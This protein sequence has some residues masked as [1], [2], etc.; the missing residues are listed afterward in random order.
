MSTNAF[1]YVQTQLDQYHSM[2]VTDKENIPYWSKRAHMALKAYQELLFTLLW[3]DKYGSEAVKE[4]SRVIKS[5]VFYMPEYRELCFS[6]LNS[7]D[8]VKLSKLYLKDLVETNHLFLKMLEEYATSSSRKILVKTKGQ[9]RKKM[10]RS[11]NKKGAKKSRKTIPKDDEEL[12]ELWSTVCH[13]IL[14]SVESSVGPS[15]EA[16]NVIPFDAASDTPI[17]EQKVTAVERISVFLHT[18]KYKEAFVLLK[19][20][21]EVWPDCREEFGEQGLDPVDETLVLKGIFMRKGTLSA[22]NAALRGKKRIG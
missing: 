21:R 3:M 8:P 12:D 1:H 7:F 4:S 15:D 22:A 14:E 20:S 2:M 17:E 6:L 18:R 19:A 16:E 11:G 9:K 10:K 5:N 13:D